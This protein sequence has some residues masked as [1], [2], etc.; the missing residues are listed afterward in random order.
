MKP[1]GV[2]SEYITVQDLEK[3]AREGAS[4]GDGKPQDPHA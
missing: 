2:R 4:T 3:V 1:K